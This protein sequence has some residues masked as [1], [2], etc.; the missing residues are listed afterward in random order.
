MKL[1]LA[2][3]RV[4]EIIVCITSA[5]KKNTNSTSLALPPDS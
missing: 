1:K 5:D 2:Y 4:G 3:S